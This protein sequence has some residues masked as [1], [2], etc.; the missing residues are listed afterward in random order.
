[1]MR[2]RPFPAIPAVLSPRHRAKTLDG[3]L[4]PLP[5]N[6]KKQQKN[7]GIISPRRRGVIIK[8]FADADR[9]KSMY[10][11]VTYRNLI[12]LMV[13]LKILELQAT[14]WFLVVVV[15]RRI[16]GEIGWQNAVRWWIK[17]P[18]KV[19]PFWEQCIHSSLVQK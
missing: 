11:F 15:F 16:E 9:Q 8:N 13:N 14:R 3:L 10:L 5:R 19:W 1:M 4:V 12:K 2:K 6:K 18:L 17:M 7:C